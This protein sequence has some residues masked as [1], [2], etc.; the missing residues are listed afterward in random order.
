MWIQPYHRDRLAEGQ[1]HSNFG[2]VCPTVRVTDPA[3]SAPFAR[4][5]VR[6]PDLTMPASRVFTPDGTATELPHYFQE[7]PASFSFGY[8]E[9]LRAN[10][11]FPDH[12][13][14]LRDPPDGILIDESL[15]HSHIFYS[16][17]V[18]VDRSTNWKWRVDRSWDTALLYERQVNNCYH[19]FHYQY[20][21]WFIDCLPRIWMFKNQ[22]P[23]AKPEKWL[24]GPMDRAFHLPSLELFDI[25]QK[26]CIWFQGDTVAAFDKLVT[27]AF[28]FEEPLK[29][30][31]PGFQ[32]GTFH[33]GWSAPYV[34]DLRDRAMTRYGLKQQ[35]DLLIYI[36]RKDAGH[37][38]IRNEAALL[39]LL[40]A[41]GFLRVVAGELS[42]QQQ[43]ELFSRA[44]GIVA[45]HG[46]GLTN[47]LWAAPGCTILEFQPDQLGDVG[48]RFL[49]QICG[50]DHSAILC[51]PFDHP[52]GVPY[53]DVEVDL[54][55][56]RNAMTTLFGR[57]VVPAGG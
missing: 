43:V 32:S 41:H 3:A 40:D 19:R 18:R 27:P 12:A 9:A 6:L 8:T 33:K 29:T 28:T 45:V 2:T 54:D 39:D 36:T 42:F 50:H 46:A 14:F 44:R 1:D 20:F 11:F 38:Q 48:Y 31:R 4:S 21:H 16:K 34:T 22:S 49:A 17:Y 57:R 35:S 53:A 10:M 52:Q 51:H 15:W 56:F 25:D 26:D 5:I 37:R 55:S 24:I 30:M 47:M 7:C 13:V 23:W